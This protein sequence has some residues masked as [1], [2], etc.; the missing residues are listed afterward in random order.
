MRGIQ[1]SLAACT[2]EDLPRRR[3][4]LNNWPRKTFDWQ[5]P[6]SIFGAAIA[7]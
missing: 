6:A 1:A 2:A 7:A 5:A 3:E 4:R